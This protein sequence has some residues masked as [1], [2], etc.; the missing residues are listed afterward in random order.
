[1]AGVLGRVSGQGCGQGRQAGVQVH[2]IL[3]PRLC[4]CLGAWMRT[5]GQT[6]L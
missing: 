2:R 4:R 6:K 1:V 3:G 5:L